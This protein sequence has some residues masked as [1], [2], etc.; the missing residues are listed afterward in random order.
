VASQIDLLIA[1][2]ALAANLSLVTAST[3]EFERIPSLR[4]ENWL[5]E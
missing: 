2:H 1:A 4:V 5:I 3:R